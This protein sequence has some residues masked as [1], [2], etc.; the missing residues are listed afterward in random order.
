MLSGV[1]CCVCT[2]VKMSE[3][4]LEQQTNIKFLVNLNK[5]GSEIWEMLKQVYIENA[6]K[7]T[8]VYKWNKQF[9]TVREQVTDEERV[10]WAVTIRTDKNIAKI[11]QT[12][13]ANQRLTSD[14]S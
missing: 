1:H 10:G 4:A 2:V 9:P 12:V 7:K 5:S 3:L 14:Q 8:L 13:H 6:I 11:R